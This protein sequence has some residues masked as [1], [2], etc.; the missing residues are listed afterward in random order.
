M[1]YDLK[2]ILELAEEGSFAVPAFNVYNVETLLGC[3]L[4]VY[5]AFLIKCRRFID[6]FG[7]EKFTPMLYRERAGK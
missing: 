5:Y 7:K 4:N 1:R 6:L 3:G 2:E